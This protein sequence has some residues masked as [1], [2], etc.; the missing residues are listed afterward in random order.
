MHSHREPNN[1]HALALRLG[2]D[3][4]QHRLTYLCHNSRDLVETWR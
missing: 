4:A 2:S 1:H 3:T